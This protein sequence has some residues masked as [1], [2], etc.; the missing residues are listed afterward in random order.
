MRRR[1]R[2]VKKKSA[3]ISTAIFITILTIAVFPIAFWQTGIAS[4]CDDTDNWNL[5]AT[6]TLKGYPNLTEY[7]WQKNATM[8][9]NG[10][11]DKIGLHRLV[12]TNM[13]SRGV[14]FLAGCPMWGAG[15]QRITNLPNDTITKNE[16][17]S[18]AIYWAN[19]GFDVY[20]IDYRSHFIPTTLNVSQMSFALNWTWDVW[21]SDIKEATTQLK[22]VSHVDKFF[23][24][25]ECTG[26]EAAL[27]YATKYGC[28]L[29]GIILLEPNWPPIAGYP[30]VGTTNTTNTFNLTQ[31]LAMVVATSNYTNA[32]F[33][34]LRPLANIA[35]QNASAPAIYPNG[36]SLQ[37]A[38]NP[39]TN[40]T[41][42]NITEWFSVV[43]Y[44]NFGAGATNMLPLGAYSN[45]LGGYGNVTMD[46]YSIAN[47][48]PLPMRLFLENMAMADWIN[49]PY[50]PFDYNDHYKDINVPIVAYV[51]GLYSN[52]TGNL[53][54]VNG[55]ANRDFTATLLP[56]YGH[57]DSFFGNFAARDE[58]VPATVWM[59]NHQTIHMRIGHPI[60]P[61]C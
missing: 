45:T 18:D 28:D 30:V 52:R 22:A 26:A 3:T 50:V 4:A 39:F 11:Y 10:P 5:T 8:A 31:A 42:A 41:W 21:V 17:F 58:F 40:K 56:Q 20:A 15:A 36:T 37:P 51:A 14:V 49:C 25:G 16:N 57:L 46:I 12:N 29:K 27:N 34:N 9:P 60:H 48:E 55:T 43:I 35:L 13:P 54:F 53:T 32:P 7:I 19:R 61:T 23:M 33:I 2:K 24:A 1:Q 44:N 38:I 59:I 47:S 6:N